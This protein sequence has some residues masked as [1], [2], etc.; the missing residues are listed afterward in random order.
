MKFCM[1]DSN[2]IVA[3]KNLERSGSGFNFILLGPSDLN[4]LRRARM[5]LSKFQLLGVVL[6]KN[7]T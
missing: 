2:L 5:L 1:L 3:Y 4:S 7:Y 6:S